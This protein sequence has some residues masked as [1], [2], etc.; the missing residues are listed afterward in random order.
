MSTPT[1]A[2]THNLIAFLEKP[3]KC[4]GFKQIVDFINANPIKYALTVSPTIYTSCIKQFWT[5][6]KI[7]TINDDVR[8]QALI[9]GKNVVINEASIRHDRKLNDA[10]GQFCDSDIEVAFRKHTCYIRDLEGVDLL[11]GSRGS[12]LYTLPLEDMMLSSPICLLS[13]A[14]KTKSWLWHRSQPDGFVDQDNPNHVYKLKKALYGLK[15]ALRAWQRHLAGINL[16][17]ESC[18]PVDTPIVEKS[19]LD[20]VPQGK[21]VDPTS[22]RE[23]IGSLMYLKTSRPDLVFSVCICARYQDSCIA[24]TTYADA[25]QASCQDTRRSTPGRITSITVNGKNTYELKGKFLDDLHKNAFSGTNGEDAVEHI[26]YF[27]KIVDPID[28]PNGNQD[29]LRVVVFPISLVGD[30]WRWFD[31]IKGS[32]TRALWDSWKLGSDEIEPTNEEPSY[33]KETD[34]DDEQEIGEIFRIETNLFDYETSLCEKFKKFN[35]LLKI[36]HDLLTKDIEGFKNYEEYKDDWIYDGTKM[37]HGKYRVYGESEEARIM[38]HKR[39]VQESPQSLTTYTAYHS[40]SIH[41]ILD[42]DELKDL[43]MTLKNTSY[44]H[45]RYAV[46]NTLVNEEEQAC[47]TQ[48]AVSIKKTRRIR[49]LTSRALAAMV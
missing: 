32:I 28:L 13:K 30:A 26:E 36:D 27:L 18:D 2:K 6:V 1:F 17:I 14:S 39:K 3:S 46:Y 21:E 16:C 44:P 20:A 23:M 12:N 42:F 33:L 4:D 10:E 31:G 15:Q 11:K 48:Y 7:K 43:C 45:Q 19:K 38:E 35:Y 24:L 22:C 34:H 9:D 8:L 29:K 25:D 5:T 47:F 41:H 37:C 49:A 40:K